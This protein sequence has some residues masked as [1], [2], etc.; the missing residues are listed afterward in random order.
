[1]DRQTVEY[2]VRLGDEFHAPLDGEE[3][4]AIEKVAFED[5]GVQAA[6]AKLNLPEGTTIIIDP[7]PY[8]KNSEV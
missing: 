1:M 6:I 7:W 3:I 8:G 5:A 2:N 4:V